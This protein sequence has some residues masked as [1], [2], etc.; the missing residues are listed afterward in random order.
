MFRSRTV[1]I[2]AA[3]LATGISGLVAEFFL[4]T[5]ASYFIGDT[6]VQWTLVLSIMLFSMGLGSHSSKR[7]KRH[8]LTTF[9]LI[10]I[11]LSLLI[12]LAPLLVY[13]VAGYWQ[14]IHLLVYGLAA[15][16][17]FCIGFEIPLATRLN[18][19]IGRAHV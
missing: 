9:V 15:L 17:G 10:E 3:I 12:G 5:L 7:V 14:Y 11:S 2:K 19:E 8:L 16:T 1:W 6:V 13:A 18:E 4:S